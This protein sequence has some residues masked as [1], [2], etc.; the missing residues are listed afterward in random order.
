[1]TGSPLRLLGRTATAL[2]ALSGRAAVGAVRVAGAVHPLTEH[3]VVNAAY[4]VR[5]DQ[6]AAEHRRTVNAQTEALIR[7]QSVGRKQA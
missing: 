3:A 1:M 6:R 5:R 7:R 4:A 2:G